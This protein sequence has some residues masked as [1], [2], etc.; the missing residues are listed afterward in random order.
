[1]RNSNANCGLILYELLTQKALSG[2]F[3]LHSP[4]ND[5]LGTVLSN[6]EHLGRV[7]DLGKNHTWTNTWGSTDGTS[8]S[9]GFQ[10]EVKTNF[11][12][13][14]KQMIA[15]QRH[16]QSLEEQLLRKDAGTSA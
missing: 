7:R 2:E 4:N 13:M 10:N 9:K 14:Q 15:L 1:M 8:K 3:I 16:V 11:G 12:M 6:K 5:I